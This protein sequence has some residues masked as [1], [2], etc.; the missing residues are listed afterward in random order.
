MKI[1]A[2]DP[3]TDSERKDRRKA[4]IKKAQDKF[5]AANR[6][7][8]NEK[9]R[10]ARKSDLPANARR[11]RDYRARRPEVIAAIEARRVRPEGFRE[12]F[13]AYRQEWAK[14]NPEKLSEYA[15][16]RS[17]RR[18]ARLPSGTI[19]RIGDGQGWKCA[20]CL[21]DLK[22]TGYHKDHIVPL[23]LGG[24]HVP[25]NI[26]LLCPPCNLSKGAKHPVDFMQSKGKLL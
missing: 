25:L 1:L 10:I 17:G 15:H 13:N 6:D 26:Q 12:K 7:R 11:M 19:Q 5:R 20:A 8:L 9:Q 22:K 14:A 21:K 23:T 4:Q 16:K 24:E 2:I 18:L 3:G